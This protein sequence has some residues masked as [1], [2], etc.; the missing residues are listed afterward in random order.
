[1]CPSFFLSFKVFLGIDEVSAIVS[2]VFDYVWLLTLAAL[3]LQ[4]LF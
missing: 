4:G 2:N 1:M 3:S